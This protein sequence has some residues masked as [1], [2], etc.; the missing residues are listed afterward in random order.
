MTYNEQYQF[1]K[2]S[3]ICSMGEWPNYLK[4]F[5]IES[6]MLCRNN[7]K[8]Q[9]TWCHE[10]DFIPK[11]DDIEFEIILEQT[12]RFNPN[13]LFIFGASYFAQ[14]CRLERLVCNCGSIKKKV[15]WYG[16]PEGNERM[17]QKYD[18]VLTNSLALRDSLRQKKVRSEQ[19]NHAFES[20]TL[21]LLSN[22]TKKNRRIGF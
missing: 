17:F 7:A 4:E 20:R 13:I 5:G 2:E 10:N 14:N 6:I 8:L 15:C 18:L 22:R 19:L 1:I 9:K 3:T 16:A 11:S 12:K 21:S